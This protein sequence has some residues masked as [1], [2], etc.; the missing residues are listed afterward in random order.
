LANRVSKDHLL[1]PLLP[2]PEP[3][4]V[5]VWLL[6]HGAHMRSFNPKY[7]DLQQREDE[8][9]IPEVRGRVNPAVPRRI[10]RRSRRCQR[11]IVR[12][13]AARFGRYR[14]SVATRRR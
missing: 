11:R 12:C 7:G 3:E 6:P 14:L 13:C 9:P 10:P 5:P 1:H 2:V 4:P 8:E